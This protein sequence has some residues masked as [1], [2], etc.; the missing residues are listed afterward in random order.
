MQLSPAF[1]RAYTHL[2]TIGFP[3]LLLAAATAWRSAPPQEFGEITVHR[4]NVVEPDGTLKMVISNSALMHPGVIGGDT[5]M[6]GRVRPAGIT[7]FDDRGDE[8]GGFGITG[9]AE[10][11]WGGVLFDQIN[12]DETLR[13]ITQQGFRDGEFRHQAG[14]SITDRNPKY[15]LNEVFKFMNEVEAISDPEARQARI[16]ELEAMGVMNAN[17][18][19]V[20]RQ[21]SGDVLVDLRDSNGRPRLRMLVESGGAARIEFLDEAGM[22]VR[23]LT[24]S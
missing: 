2:A 14:L 10:Q 21:P 3:A 9:N 7:F 8:M 23:T 20:G 19:F 4:I 18:M 1:R 16:K 17:R 12:N 24:G 11:R 22:V 6:P 15:S 5:L 13:L